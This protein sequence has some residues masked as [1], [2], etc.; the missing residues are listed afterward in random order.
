MEHRSTLRPE[1]H[2]AP[3][4]AFVVRDEEQQFDSKLSHLGRM[5][6]RAQ[7]LPEVSRREGA[8]GGPPFSDARASAQLVPIWQ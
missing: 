3:T 7:Q 6:Q 2:H 1:R 5:T 4:A 8:P